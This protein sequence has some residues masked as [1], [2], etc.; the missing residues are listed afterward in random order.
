[1][2]AVDGAREHRGAGRLRHLERFAGEVRLVHHALAVFDHAVHRTD[3]VRE[4]DDAV[5]DADGVERDVLDMAV[6]APVRGRRH[7]SGEC[8]QH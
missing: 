4:D 2:F 3:F 6:G 8:L 5:V 1:M 7:P